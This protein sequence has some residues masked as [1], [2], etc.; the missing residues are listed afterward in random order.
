MQGLAK[1]IL[2]KFQ[3]IED[4]LELNHKKSGGRNLLVVNDSGRVTEERYYFF[5]NLKDEN[6]EEFLELARENYGFLEL[7]EEWDSLDEDE[8]PLEGC[9]PGGHAD[10]LFSLNLEGLILDEEGKNYITYTR[11]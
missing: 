5:D 2:D 4:Y 9:E 3:E 6:L 1:I 11:W 8:N 10:I 7:Q